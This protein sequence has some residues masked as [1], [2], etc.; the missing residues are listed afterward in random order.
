MTE[1][2]P[3]AGCGQF[4]DETRRH[5]LGSK[6]DERHAVVWRRQQREIC[7]GGRA[8]H[9][10]VVDAGFVRRK[11]RAFQVDAG[12]AGVGFDYGCDRRH[13]GGHFFRAI[14]DERRQ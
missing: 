6:R 7:G 1:R 4:A 10:P 8:K 11:K 13:S 9:A 14:A 2:N 12:N 3:N 5:L